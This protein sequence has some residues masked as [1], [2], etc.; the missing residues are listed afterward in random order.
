[1]KKTFLT[2][3]LGMT[4]SLPFSL[5]Y[6]KMPG[7][8]FVTVKANA[9]KDTLFAANEIL[10][11][12]Q[13]NRNEKWV[14]SKGEPKTKEG[15]RVYLG[16]IAAEKGNMKRSA[17]KNPQ[18]FRMKSVNNGIAILGKT[19]LGTLY[20][21][22][23]FLQK[24]CDIWMPLPGV[25][26]SGLREK[27][28]LIRNIDFTLSP[29]IAFR[30]VY[31]TG[32]YY[33]L[34]ETRQKWYAFNARNRISDTGGAPHMTKLLRH[35]GGEYKV[36]NV[37][38][39]GSHTFLAY[40][41]PK[42]YAKTHPEYYSLNRNGVRDFRRSAGGQLC[43][44]NED[45]YRIVEKTL[46]DA[47]AKDRAKYPKNYPL[48]YDFSQE[49][50]TNYI[51]CCKDCKKII[52]KYGSSDAGLV[53]NFVNRLARNVKKKYP[54][55]RIRT[56]AYVSTE[57]L[58]SGIK[59]EDNVIVQF[60][61]LYSQCNNLHALTHPVNIKREQLLSNWCKI[62][63]N[64]M[65]WDYILQG[66][67][68]PLDLVSAI[69]E[70]VKF[71]RK[72]HIDWIFMETEFGKE[73]CNLVHLKN[74]VLGQFY[75]NADQDLDKLVD[76]YCRAAFGKAY[77]EMKEYFYFLQKSQK[78]KVTKEM[79]SWHA[80]E[81]AHITIP[82]LEKAQAMVKKAMTKE[83]DP[84][85]TLEM[86]R[87]L[88]AVEMALVKL[89]RPNPKLNAKRAA[90]EKHL[91]ANRIKLIQSYGWDKKRTN[92]II[93]EI[94]EASQEANLVFTD[95]PEE[96]KSI[97]RKD[98]IFIGH[99]RI[100][101]GGRNAQYVKDKDS[102][103]PRVLRW[104]SL[105]ETAYKLKFGCGVYDWNWKKTQPGSFTVAKDEKYHWYKV[106]RRKKGPF[107]LGPRSSFYSLDWHPQIKFYDLYVI[108]DGAE[109]N[110]NLYDLWVSM[111]FEG[112]AYN[113]D[114][115][116]ENAIYFERAILVRK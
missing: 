103:M 5:L 18:S 70:D 37:I 108:S 27:D 25:D 17:L 3:F 80:R 72:N 44:S 89:Y 26:Y 96:L 21:G 93:R 97:P 1:M 29:T 28:I 95:I 53:L 2:V 78:E 38:G 73:P 31:H 30:S 69:P 32:Y 36:S 77:P 65:L 10:S 114:S 106:N 49:D 13:K 99:R 42:K 84:A 23:E 48:V 74:F 9:D 100:T 67:S 57:K 82:M 15:I 34:R 58:P 33:T 22:Y 91:L 46:L 87:E 75:F 88:N 113:P 52:D 98:L 54:D 94:R 102:S 55:V 47:I 51:C 50:N 7:T 8:N 35:M 61:D 12:L 71:F 39:T 16:E 92:S 45:V 4:L 109:K 14:L 62:T 101:S 59:P 24:C 63:K 112:T 85:K 68:L 20:G 83:K 40:V 115:T 107:E 76:V 19:P 66:G 6:G 60:C 110:P 41:P 43:L 105:K 11:V 111:K 56:F 86:L 81:L 116:K 104:R 79:T 64:M 90:I